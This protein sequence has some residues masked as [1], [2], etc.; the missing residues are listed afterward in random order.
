MSTLKTIF[1][2]FMLVIQ[3]NFHRL[4]SVSKWM[5]QAL[6]HFWK[7]FNFFSQWSK[8]IYGHKVLCISLIFKHLCCTY[9]HRQNI[10]AV[11]FFG[12]VRN[13]VAR[14]RLHLL[15]EVNGETFYIRRYFLPGGKK[16]AMIKKSW[17]QPLAVINAYKEMEKEELV[18]K[19]SFVVIQSVEMQN[20]AGLFQYLMKFR[21]VWWPF[22]FFF[23]VRRMESHKYE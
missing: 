10:R 20:S 17:G 15:A 21:M 19:N 13:I 5:V 12:C 18:A 9:C 2:N 22:A 6:S 23:S 16:L 4:T 3:T 7:K 14:K 11:H 1:N 8:C